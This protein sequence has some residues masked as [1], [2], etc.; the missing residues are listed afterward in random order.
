M[1]EESKKDISG[2]TVI[3]PSYN[4][5]E[6]LVGVVAG[7]AAHGFRDIVLIDDGSGMG[8]KT[9]FERTIAEKPD[10]SEINLLTHEKNRGKGEALKT[11]FAFFLENRPESPGIVTTDDDGQHMPQDARRCAQAMQERG[12][13][14][15][16]S[17]RFNNPETPAKSLAGNR[18]MSFMFKAFAG[19]KITDTQ[20]GLRAIPR[21]Y[22]PALVKIGGRRFEYETAMLINARREGFKICEVPIETVYVDGNRASH[23]RPAA[24]S[25]LI[26]LQFI[27][28]AAASFAAM[29]RR[30]GKSA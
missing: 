29:L 14:V 11:G 9:I 19:V 7:L 6:T 1:R 2:V 28:C 22:V 20:T 18:F 10:G 13:L 26:F 25:A 24:D 17:R 5:T 4:P 27:K 15:L 12:E 3:L 21:G 30:G 16:G 8:S 23:F